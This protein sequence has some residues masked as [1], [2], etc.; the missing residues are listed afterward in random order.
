MRKL[1][2]LL[3]S[4]LLA[5][6]AS[7]SPKT[8]AQV[9]TT[10][11]HAKLAQQL[12]LLGHRNWILIVDSAYPLQVSPG[13]EVI[14]TGANQLAVIT[15][16]LNALDHS[17]H[18]TPVIYL[19][20]ELP[21]VPQQNFTGL[22]A[23]RENL[24]KTLQGRPVHSLPHEQLIGKVSEAGKDFRIL[25]LKTN[26]AMPYTSVF[27]QLDCRY[28]GPDDEQKLRQAMKASPPK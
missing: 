14:E 1:R 23:Y 26:M 22:N 18:V 10:D 2:I 24:K 7:F 21:Y 15:T 12:P 16:V 4:L 11:W 19:D 8:P 13:I 5:A 28:W 27:L 9:P 6:T 17:I 25:V 3:A 20:A